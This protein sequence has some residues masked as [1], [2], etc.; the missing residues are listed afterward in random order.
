VGE[1]PVSGLRR[2]IEALMGGERPRPFDPLAAG[3]NL[4]AGVYAGVGRLR[5]VLYRR[6]VL[7]ARRLPC[8]VI[9]IGNLTVGGTGK[10][11][12]AIHVAGLL[13]QLGYR[14]A[15]ISRGYGGL[16]EKTG[17]VVSDGATLRMTAAEAGDEPY[18]M[19]L[20]LPGV[21]V[22]VGSSRR[23]AG[24]R[25]LT[26]F[27]VDILVLDDAYQHLQ[28]ARDLNLLLLDQ[29]A[30]FGNGRV[31]PRGV[32]RE[33]ASALSRADAVVFTRATGNVG[34][35]PSATR[36]PGL[37]TGVPVFYCRHRPYVSGIVP[38]GK[39]RMAAAAPRVA[40]A[41]LAGPPTVAFSG[42]ARN[43]DFLQTLVGLGVRV[44]AALAFPDHHRYSEKDLERIRRAARQT[45]ARQLVTT[46]KD[47]VR[48]QP[49]GVWPLPLGV[50][51][52]RIDF[53]DQFQAFSDFIRR[54]TADFFSRGPRP[55]RTAGWSASADG[56]PP[57]GPR[58][59]PPRC[60]G[61]G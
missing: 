40:A 19:A 9:A 47:F 22:V 43:D 44:S 15:V 45:G 42:I 49:R 57:G 55:D 35:G 27:G 50:V 30:P 59:D 31:L 41:G 51:G 4:A 38:V 23:R 32:L 16:A 3:L 14:V 39:R 37:G 58:G 48:I 13:Q 26:A 56:S 7:R 17:G 33:P 1:Q 52:V 6:G 60:S 5:A 8:P 28:L 10:T 18:L 2:R 24:F 25:A 21:P 61:G 53:G 54:R 12:M 46:H 34:H 11:P 29:A 20:L 36:L